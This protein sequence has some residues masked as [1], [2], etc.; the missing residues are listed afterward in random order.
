M[1]VDGIV[2]HWVAQARQQIQRLPY[3][4]SLL[5]TTEHVNTKRPADTWLA[6]RLDDIQQSPWLAVWPLALFIVFLWLRR[7]N[8]QP[9]RYQVPSPRTPDKKELLSNP[10]IKVCA[11]TRTH[12]EPRPGQTD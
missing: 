12:T 2:E 3:V 1:Q 9:V 10:S 5:P 6:A 7:E 8:D 11:H 4:T